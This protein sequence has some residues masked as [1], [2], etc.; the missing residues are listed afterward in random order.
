M[1]FDMYLIYILVSHKQAVRCKGSLAQKEVRFEAE[2]TR[3]TQALCLE[4]SEVSEAEDTQECS[5]K[6]GQL[7]PKLLS[8]FKP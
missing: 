5:K 8:P 2:S 6:L 1:L 4:A 3:L 7:F